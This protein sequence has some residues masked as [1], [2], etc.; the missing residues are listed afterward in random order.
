MESPQ[1]LRLLFWSLFRYQYLLSSVFHFIMFKII[2]WKLYDFTKYIKISFS[3]LLRQLL[4]LPIGTSH[5]SL[6]AN[7]KIVQFIL[8]IQSCGISILCGGCPH[9]FFFFLY[10]HLCRFSSFWASMGLENCVQFQVLH[11]K[12]WPNWKE[13]EEHWECS[14]NLKNIT[15]ELTLNYLRW[16]KMGVR[17]GASMVTNARNFCEENGAGGGNLFL[18]SI[19]CRM[20]SYM[21]KSKQ[22]RFY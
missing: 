13:W 5:P 14:A 11:F 10:C 1:R 16:K 3:I 18:V 7:K 4:Y 8:K 17:N 15:Y 2:F 12:L 21:L 6:P 19:V 9:F 22:K 20:R